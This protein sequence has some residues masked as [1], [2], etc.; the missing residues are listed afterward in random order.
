MRRYYSKGGSSDQYHTT[1]DGRK[2]NASGGIAG[3]LGQ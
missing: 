3:M 1:K 2:M